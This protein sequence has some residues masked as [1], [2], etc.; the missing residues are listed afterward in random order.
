MDILVPRMQGGKYIHI[1]IHTCE[2]VIIGY[3]GVQSQLAA[4][5]VGAVEYVVVVNISL[6]SIAF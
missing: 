5:I 2:C 3:A 6:K 4:Y 1:R